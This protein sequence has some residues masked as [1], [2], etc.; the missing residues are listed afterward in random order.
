MC[1][2]SRARPVFYGCTSYVHRGVRIHTIEQ[3][4]KKSSPRQRGPGARASYPRCIL[5]K[6]TM[7]RGVINS[8]EREH[9]YKR[10]SRLCAPREKALSTC[11][12]I[13]TAALLPK[14][15]PRSKR[16]AP[17][18]DRLFLTVAQQCHWRRAAFHVFFGGICYTRPQVRRRWNPT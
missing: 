9:I 14:Q 7:R 12:A 15:M 8:F 18:I 1:A 3:R 17:T 13:G 4:G 6:C 16:S 2:V 11:P 5:Y 10:R